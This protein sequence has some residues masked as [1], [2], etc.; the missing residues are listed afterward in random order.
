MS[1]PS[2]KRVVTGGIFLA[3]GSLLL[4]DNLDIFRFNIPDYFFRWYT[5][6]ILLGVF[7]ATVKE[8]VGLGLTLMIVGGLFLLR[9]LSWEYRW[10]IDFLD[11]ANFW[12]LI[13]VAI[14]LSLIFKHRRGGEDYQQ[15]KILMKDHQVIM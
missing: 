5:F 2:N 14:G 9:E 10:D 11:F 12:P 8:K 13:F 1:Q 4:L 15:K 6:L 3:V 7:F